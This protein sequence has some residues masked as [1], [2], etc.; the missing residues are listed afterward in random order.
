MVTS[1]VHPGETPASFVFNGFLD[2]ILREDD[3]RAKQLRRQYVFKLIPMLNP[4]GVQRGHYRTDSRGV[5]LNR[6][7]LDPNFQL[8]PSIYA[9]KA[10]LVYHHVQN[11]KEVKK[12]EESEESPRSKSMQSVTA[13]AGRRKQSDDSTKTEDCTRDENAR[14]ISRTY[15]VVYENGVSSTTIQETITRDE[16][17]IVEELQSLELDDDLESATGNTEQEDVLSENLAAIESQSEIDI[18]EAAAETKYINYTEKENERLISKHGMKDDDDSDGRQSPGHIGNEGSDDE[19]G[20]NMDPPPG[21]NG[22]VFTPHLSDPK[23]TEISPSESGI[24]FYVDLHGHASKRGCFIYGNYFE[25]EDTQIENMLFPKLI[26]MNT[27]HF[28]FTGCNFTE[29][30]M[31]MKDK[32]DGLSK[33]GSGRVAIYKALGIIHRYAFFK[34]YIVNERLIIVTSLLYCVAY[35]LSDLFRGR[36]K[37]KVLW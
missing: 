22:I 18:S 32:R 7:Y 4:D 19:A 30:N 15:N 11:K 29:R 35:Y 37:T 23:L 16:E 10:L 28:D 34:K 9:S 13:S 26:S 6:M 2:F 12:K 8:Y 33:E 36:V 31:Y 25:N 3:P 1:R 5:N 27:A 24:A 14:S 20:G 17:Q 21:V